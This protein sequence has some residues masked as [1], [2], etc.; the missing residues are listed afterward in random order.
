[1]YTMLTKENA[2]RNIEDHAGIG[3][4]RHFYAQLPEEGKG[5]LKSFLQGLASIQAA[6]A[7]GMPPGQFLAPP[8]KGKGEAY[9]GQ[10]LGD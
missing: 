9:F 7:G 3:F 5:N 6:V 1:M 8:A 10:R 4:L 2:D